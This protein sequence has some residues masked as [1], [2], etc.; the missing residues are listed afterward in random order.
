MSLIKFNKNRFPLSSGLSNFFDRDLLF[1]DDFF[2][3]EKSLPAMNVKEHDKDFEIELASPGFNKKDFEIT[4]KDDVLEVSAQKGEE[5]EENEDD[6]TRKEFNYRS[7]RRS[8]QL[9]KTVDNTKD[10]KATY[11]N[12]ILKLHLLKKEEAEEKAK[13]KIEVA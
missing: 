5:E 4:M 1:D 3:L 11:K 13:R 2:N 12:G 10:V 6:Y 8:L 9:P 7:F